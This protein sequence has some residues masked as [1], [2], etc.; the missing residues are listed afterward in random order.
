MLW[1]LAASATP[2][3][4]YDTRGKSYLEARHWYGDTDF[5]TKVE[6]HHLQV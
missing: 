2:L 4:T 6:F 1:F 3:Y 5:G